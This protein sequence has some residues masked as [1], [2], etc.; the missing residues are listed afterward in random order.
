[1]RRRGVTRRREPLQQRGRL[2]DV[3]RGME[4]DPMSRPLACAAAVAVLMLTGCGTAGGPG[5]APGDGARGRPAAG[6]VTGRL[7]LEG[8][9]V[10][11][12]GRQPGP[13]AIP[14]VVTFTIAGHRPV[15]VRA[16]RSGIFTVRLPPGRYRVS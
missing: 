14:G 13:R 6:H 11:P 4:G 12:G 3:Q 5:P 2:S 9:P 16:G 15:R 10:R 8:G 1:M 7:V